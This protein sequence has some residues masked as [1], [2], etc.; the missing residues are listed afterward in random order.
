[1][2][3]PLARLAARADAARGSFL[4]RRANARKLLMCRREGCKAFIVL[5]ID[6]KKSIRIMQLFRAQRARFKGRAP[7]REVMRPWEGSTSTPFILVRATCHESRKTF[8]S[9]QK[10]F[11]KVI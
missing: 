8:K 4:L 7:R 5:I 10:N 1:M 9:E 2:E 6:R 11:Y 3:K